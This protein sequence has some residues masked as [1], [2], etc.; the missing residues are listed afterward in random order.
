MGW[1]EEFQSYL[2]VGTSSGECN[3]QEWETRESI[4]Y[5]ANAEM[6]IL[7]D[8]LPW[9]TSWFDNKWFNSNE[10]TYKVQMEDFSEDAWWIALE[11][12]S[13]NNIPNNF[14][15]EIKHSSIIW[16]ISQLKINEWDIIELEQEEPN[17]YNL[18]IWDKIYKI[19]LVQNTMIDITA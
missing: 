11:L 12:L 18:L 5:D 4:C 19:D 9:E 6:Q 8:S 7:L 2:D 13:R 14:I 15:N 10:D 16:E 17:Q 1:Q 3:L